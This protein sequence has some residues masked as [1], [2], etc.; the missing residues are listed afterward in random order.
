MR[1]EFLDSK[2]SRVWR[3]PILDLV[4]GGLRYS[5]GDAQSANLG[6]GGAMKTLQNGRKD[7]HAR[8]PTEADRQSQPISS[9]AAKYDANMRRTADIRKVVADNVAK[10]SEHRHGK[11]NKT[12]L[13]ADTNINLGGAQRVLSGDVGVGIDLLE[14][15]ADAYGLEVWQ[16]LVPNFD[17]QKPP[18]LSGRPAI[19]N[20]LEQ[21]L[22]DFY[23]HM[24]D[25]RKED[26]IAL[27]NRWA[28]DD[29]E[30]SNVN[31]YPK[32]RIR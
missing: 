19:Q 23:R 10:V 30:P 9:G 25:E 5:A 12:R 22:L 8:K 27:A 32:G 29:P 28:D 2:N 17:P 20:I 18:Q 26:L 31:P 4:N 7:V 13:G 21:Q 3:L 6:F 14:K 24:P 15:I 16:L 1:V 11:V